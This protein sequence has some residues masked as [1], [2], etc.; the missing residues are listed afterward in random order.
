MQGSPPGS[1]C[2]GEWRKDT[3]FPLPDA[4]T[5]F[6]CNT[7]EKNLPGKTMTSHFTRTKKYFLGVL[8]SS[9]FSTFWV[10]YTR[11]R[12]AH[13]RSVL[14]KIHTA[15]LDNTQKTFTPYD[16]MSRRASQFE[17]QLIRDR[18][19]ARRGT[20]GVRCGTY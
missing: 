6:V 15:P 18:Q 17:L 1:K 14:E 10:W 9:T 3:L 11:Y 7:Y 16:M 4:M 20:C 13:D 5:I 8:N 19:E 2:L 12:R